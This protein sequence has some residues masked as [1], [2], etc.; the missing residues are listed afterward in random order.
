MHLL[1]IEFVKSEV[2]TPFTELVESRTSMEP[3][4]WLVSVSLHGMFVIVEFILSLE[5]YIKIKMKLTLSLLLN[6]E[7]C[8][9]RR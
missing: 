6:S 4:F 1:S 2:Y 3:T 7:N 5:L 9:G 8:Q